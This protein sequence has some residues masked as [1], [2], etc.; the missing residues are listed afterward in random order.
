MFDCRACGSCCRVLSPG[1]VPAETL[2]DLTRRDA[3]ALVPG[4]GGGAFWGQRE[5]DGG[6]A[7]FFLKVDGACIFLGPDSL[8]R[9]HAAFGAAALPWFCRV[10]PKALVAGPEGLRLG[11]APGCH[12]RHLHDGP[13][14]LLSAGVAG[15]WE[16]AASLPFRA[17]LPD[18]V[19]LPAGVS[20]PSAVYPAVERALRREIARPRARFDSVFPALRAVMRAVSLA[21]QAPGPPEPDPPPSSAPMDRLVE[22]FGLAADDVCAA[23]PGSEQSR[24]A[25]G[26]AH[27]LRGHGAPALP[28]RRGLAPARP[29]SAAAPSSGASPDAD[30]LTPGAAR[31]L[32]EELANYVFTGGVTQHR[33]LAEG[34]GAFLFSTLLCRS[35][36]AAHTG[37]PVGASALNAAWAANHLGTEWWRQ[38][39][40]L[41]ASG[42]AFSELFLSFE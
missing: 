38:V 31:F 35:H 14:T 18:G 2:A 6:A 34:F 41:E 37:E 39:A 33:G 17:V 28:G 5:R 1:P 32:A 40:S 13:A 7:A 21:L 19:S 22:V 42:A 4:L 3:G 15:L 11:W 29:G 23:F 9:I 8:C 36:A 30:T 26:V 12:G 10:F 20:I 16:D 25:A 24:A 27:L